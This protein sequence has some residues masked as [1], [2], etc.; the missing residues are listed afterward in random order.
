MPSLTSSQ[1]SFLSFYWMLAYTH[2][3]YSD[4]KEKV[5]DYI[6]DSILPFYLEEFLE[7]DFYDFIQYS[8]VLKHFDNPM[9]VCI[10]K[11]VFAVEYQYVFSGGFLEKDAKNIFGDI[12]ND[13]SEIFTSCGYGKIKFKPSSMTEIKE[14]LMRKNISD[15]YSDKCRKL[16]IE[17]V[18]MESLKEFL[19]SIDDKFSK[20]ILQWENLPCQYYQFSKLGIAIA[21]I[22][23]RM[24]GIVFDEP[25]I[26][27]TLRMIK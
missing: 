26:Q 7:E 20:F 25:S 3:T 16:I 6:V 15:K 23:C 22:N 17:S 2:R 10:L 1:I 5:R 27:K 8:N 19:L 11:N 14:Y 4:S 21:Y 18:D 9:S 12:Y 24:N 13:I